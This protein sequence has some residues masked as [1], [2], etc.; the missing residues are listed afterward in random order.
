MHGPSHRCAAP[1]SCTLTHTEQHTDLLFRG[2]CTNR[3]GLPGSSHWQ[4]Q[5]DHAAQPQRPRMHLSSMSKHRWGSCTRRPAARRAAHASR[6]HRQALRTHSSKPK[7]RR[8]RAAGWRSHGACLDSQ[9]R[10]GAHDPQGPAL[11]RAAGGAYVDV[12]PARPNAGIRAMYAATSSG[13]SSTAA[14]YCQN[15]SAAISFS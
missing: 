3:V 8:T 5:T 11:G 6:A 2:A 9:R 1:R 13:S 10:V 15:S 12:T 4:P 14:M 7:R